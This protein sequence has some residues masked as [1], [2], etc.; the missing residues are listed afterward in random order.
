VSS[1]REPRN[2]FSDLRLMSVRPQAVLHAEIGGDAPQV[3]FEEG[4]S[5]SLNA[6][7]RTALRLCSGREAD[8]E[9]LM[10]DALLRA[11][12]HR[13]SLRRLGAC[14]SWLFTILVRTHLNR[15]RA[16]RRRHERL[17]ADLPDGAFEAALADWSGEGRVDA[18]IDSLARRDEVRRALDSLDQP[19]RLV[20]LLADAEEFTHR[21][22]A[23]ML[24]IPEGT[25]ASRLFR[26][27]R[28]LRQ[29]LRSPEK[30]APWRIV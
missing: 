13:K 5:A 9:D 19:L 2:P 14:R 18:A 22:I 11:F 3:T 30:S 25:V 4:L 15:V 23:E 17:E 21:E 1:R 28:A 16:E 10:Q 27:R 24:D 6:L 7:Y 26:A 8:A 12:D 20:L 29:C